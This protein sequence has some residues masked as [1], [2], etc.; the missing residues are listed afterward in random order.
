MLNVDFVETNSILGF[1]DMQPDEYDLQQET[2]EVEHQE[3]L[4]ELE[5]LKGDEYASLDNLYEAIFQEFESAE[6]ELKA[7]SHVEE[8]TGGMVSL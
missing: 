2:I 7:K 5:L 8:A 6:A 1:I 3:V 4:K